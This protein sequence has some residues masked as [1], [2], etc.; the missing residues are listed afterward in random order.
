MRICRRMLQDL[1]GRHPYYHANGRRKLFTETEL[2][3]LRA[4]MRQEAGVDPPPKIIETSYRPQRE[5]GFVYFLEARESSRIKIGFATNL[6]RRISA[7]QTGSPERLI[8]LGTIPGTRADERNL[9]KR[10]SKY[11]LSGEWFRNAQPLLR[12]ILK[13]TR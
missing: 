4:A 2:A 13:V 9:H 11:R 7:L 6:E 5:D 10:F 8:V 1:I 12:Y 3:S